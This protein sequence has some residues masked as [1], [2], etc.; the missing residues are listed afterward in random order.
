MPFRPSLCCTLVVVSGVVFTNTGCQPL[1]TTV[2]T[3]IDFLSE[4]GIEM[5]YLSGGTLLMGTDKGEADEAP[6][7]EVTLS[8]LLIDK[9]EVTHAMFA[10]AELPNPSKWQDDPRKPVERVRWRDAKQYCN[11]RSLMEGLQPCYDETQPGWPCD[12]L[13][14]GYRLPTEAEWEFACRAGTRGDY[15][16]GQA[17]KLRQYVVFADNSDQHTHVVGTK[18]PNRWGIHD[19]YGNVSEWCHD[20]YDVDYYRRSPAR[21]PTGPEPTSTDVRRVLRGGSWKATAAMCR[22][23]FR[24]GQRT[25]DTDACFYTDDCGFRCVRRPQPTELASLGM[26]SSSP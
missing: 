4:S 13:A 18:K 23:T 5:V 20:V 22:S 3:A 21:D 12:F 24:Q 7:H 10:V 26:K 25:G 16:F 9:Y 8:P 1:G 2:P 17:N 15:D 14:S 6:R 19:M 11:E